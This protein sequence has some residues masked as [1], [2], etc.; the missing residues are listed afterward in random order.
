MAN[1]I[2]GTQTEKNLLK[3]FAGESQAARRYQIFA[4][5]A[6]HEGYQQIAAIFEETAEQE[7]TH[8]KV[9]F[10]YLQGGMVEITAS[11]PAG[12][13]G[14]TADNLE[15]AAEGENLEYTELY[16][17]FA[18]I[19]EE[20]GFK[21]VATSYKMITNVEQHHEKRYLKLLERVKEEKVFE[22]DEKVKW[23]CR[24]CGFVHEGEKALKTC[25]SCKH[26]QAY[27]EIL[28]ENY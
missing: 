20:E 27:F 5:V 17:E 2:K 22:R 24:K 23:V 25:P 21:Q 11:Y 9:F 15:E 28:A 26:P 13:I 4:N 7:K 18:K 12:K 14:T 3:S 8:A 16:P 6:R 1:N 10:E 19:A